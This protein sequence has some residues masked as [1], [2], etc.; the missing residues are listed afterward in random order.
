M[1]HLPPACHKTNKH[2]S[3]NET[4]VKEKQNKTKVKEKQNKIVP[5]SNSNLTKSMTHHNQTKEL[6]TWFLTHFV[7][8]PEPHVARGAFAGESLALQVGPLLGNL[9]Q[10]MTY[11]CSRPL[12]MI[13]SD[14][15]T[16]HQRKCKNG[17]KVV[18]LVTDG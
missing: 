13:C 4:N 17:K 8:T 1:P 14:L 2:V 5:D 15:W 6:T 11:S 3:Q 12:L 9:L 18:F 16:I 10:S 7:K